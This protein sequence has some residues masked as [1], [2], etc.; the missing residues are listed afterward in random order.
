LVYAPVKGISEVEFAQIDDKSEV[1]LEY[2]NIKLSSKGIFFPQTETICTFDFDT[3]E[4][5][6]SPE[7][8]YLVFGSRPCDAL[9]L[10]YLDKIFYEENKGYDDPYYTKRRDG[11]VTISIACN[12]PC[13]T[14]FCSS[15]GGG[16]ANTTGS[17]ILAT[18]IDD[19]YLFRSCSDRGAALLDQYKEFFEKPEDS[20]IESAE[21]IAEQAEKGMDK[22]EFTMDSL[23]KNMDDRFNDKI[24]ERI[25]Q[26]CIGCG[27]CTY[28]CPTCHCFDIVDE[29]YLRVRCWDTCSSDTFTRMAA[30]ED[31]R[32][33]KHTRYRQRV[34]HKFAYYRDN[35]DAVA[36]VGCGRCTTHCPVKIDIVEI[37]N[38]I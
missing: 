22:I 5:I 32:K 4:E 10:V 35:L 13:S 2:Q 24:W 16:P 21:K 20:L 23:K 1:V 25:T 18:A 37:V 26:D 30:G 36:C 15:V 7:G 33:Q 3:I 12:E 6:P 34:F 17:D 8:T 9:A 14:C 31:H 19:R 11:S 28:L 38:N 27:A 29:G